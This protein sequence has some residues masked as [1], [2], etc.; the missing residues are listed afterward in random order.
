MI[1]FGWLPHGPYIAYILPVSTALKSL[2]LTPLVLLADRV[3]VMNQEGQEL[4]RSERRYQKL[5]A[6]DSLTGLYNLR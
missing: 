1:S 3:K 4:V 2:L 6:T 5:S